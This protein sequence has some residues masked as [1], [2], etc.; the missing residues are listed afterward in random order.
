MTVEHFNEWYAGMRGAGRR[1]RLWQEL[2]GLPPELVS[3]SLLSMSGLREVVGILDL[4]P[5]QVLLDLACGRGGYGLWLARETGCRLVGVDFS[6]VAVE[7]AR[8]R[9]ADFGLDG[10]AE[11]HVG[12]LEAIGLP[13]ASVHAVVCVDAIQFAGD[14]TAAAAEICRVLRPGGVAVLTTWGPLDPSDEV[15]PTRIRD[16]DLA[17]A[18]PTGGLVDVQVLDRSDWL[19]GERALWSAVLAA[20]PAEDREIA[21]MREE[22][23][24]STTTLLPRVRRVLATGRAPA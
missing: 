19:A 3:T 7:D 14:H 6:T 2:L 9:V 16:L 13:E 1:D 17:R 5:D 4:Q 10:R 23:E 22:A 21:E 8:R 20:D 11:F 24:F 12:E 18:L 15:L